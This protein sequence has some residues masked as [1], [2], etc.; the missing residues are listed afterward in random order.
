VRPSFAGAS[1]RSSRPRDAAAEHQDER[2]LHELDDRAAPAE[3][4]GEGE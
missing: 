4:L 2:D 3:R 1:A